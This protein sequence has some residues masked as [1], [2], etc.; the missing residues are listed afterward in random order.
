M[1]AAIIRSFWNWVICCWKPRPTSP[2]VLLTG[3]R[4]SVNDS[5]A[6]SEDLLPSL[7]SLRLTEKP[8][9][10]VGNTI[11]DMPR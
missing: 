8:G 5:S 9:V 6:V 2:I 1:Y 10:S 3:T 4:A 7:R 11:C